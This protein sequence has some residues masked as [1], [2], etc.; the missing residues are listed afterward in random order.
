MKIKE[1]YDSEDKWTKGSRARRSDGVSVDELN[2]YAAS[3]C[4]YGAITKCYDKLEVS[5][6]TCIIYKYIKEKFNEDAITIFN[7]YVAKF[8]DIKKM[9]EILDI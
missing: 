5:K 6:I 4:L 2:P 1:L 9:V 7:D 3:W 8:K